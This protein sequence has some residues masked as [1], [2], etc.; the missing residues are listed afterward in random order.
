MPLIGGS[1]CLNHHRSTQTLQDHY[2]GIAFQPKHNNTKRL[3]HPQ[4][5]EEIGLRCEGKVPRNAG[6][7]VQP[8]CGKCEGEVLGYGVTVL[9]A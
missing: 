7:R 6:Y 2:C 5:H 4:E 9:V 8:A 3:P 1:S